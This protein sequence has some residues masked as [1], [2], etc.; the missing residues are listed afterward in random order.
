MKAFVERDQKNL[1]HLGMVKERIE[2]AARTEVTKIDAIKK[3]SS[4]LEKA[5]L[6]KRFDR[7]F[8]RVDNKNK[9]TQRL[10]HA[11]DVRQTAHDQNIK[12]SL[13][14]YQSHLS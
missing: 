4:K 1:H 6:E 14:N 5:A 2:D 7:L 8:A 3:R 10:R 11:T 12:E 9:F 13:Q